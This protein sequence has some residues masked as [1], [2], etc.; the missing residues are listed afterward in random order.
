MRRD[1]YLPELL[2]CAYGL[3]RLRY[4][5]QAWHLLQGAA[6]WQLA[7]AALWLLSSVSLSVKARALG[8][9]GGGGGGD[10]NAGSDSAAVLE[11]RAQTGA[12][13]AALFAR[14][15]SPEGGARMVGAHP[16]LAQATCRLVEHYASWF[17][18]AGDEPPL[19]GALQLMLRALVVPQV[20]GRRWGSAGVGECGQHPPAPHPCPACRHPPRLQASHTAARSF[21]Q[22]CLR[23]GWKMQDAAA[24]GWLMDAAHGALQQAGGGLPIAERQLVVE[25]LARVAAG[26]Q[27]QHLLD[28]A[29][30]LTAPF[31]QAARAAAAA[32]TNGAPAPD[33]AARR[34]LADNLRLLAAA[35]RH[36]APAGDDRGELGA[37]PALQALAQAG[38]VLQAVAESQAW[39]ADPEAVAAAVEVYRRA[40]GTAKQHGLQVG[41]EGGEGHLLHTLPC[42]DLLCSVRRLHPPPPHLLPPAAYTAGHVGAAGHGCAVCSHCAPRLP[43]CGG[44]STRDAA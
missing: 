14:V 44:G 27:G 21:Q 22:L 16:A 33:A 36:L 37:Q 23:C 5:T 32:D 31:I 4:L 2:D 15:C 29:A 43:D 6:S 26:L 35:L 28:A 7:E 1:Q 19:Q 41:G 9:G 20:R 3:L 34:G 12:L 11:D 25:G 10:E 24:F 13:L 38:P 18:Q 17:G 8:G 40:V 42:G 30:H 39:Q